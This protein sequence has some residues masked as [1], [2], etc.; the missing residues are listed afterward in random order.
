MK[1]LPFMFLKKMKLQTVV[2]EID[3]DIRHRRFVHLHE[4]FPFVRYF[5]GK[6]SSKFLKITETHK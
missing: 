5:F 4:Y 3:I 2:Y 6:I 1:K